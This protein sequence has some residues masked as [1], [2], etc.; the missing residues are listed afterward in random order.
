MANY[1]SFR[2]L[3]LCTMRWA[4]TCRFLIENCVLHASPMAEHEISTCR[5]DKFTMCAPV[6]IFRDHEGERGM[7]K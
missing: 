6:H 5:G 3:V 7:A 2:T 4:T 1:Q